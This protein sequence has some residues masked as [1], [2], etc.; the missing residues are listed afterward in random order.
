MCVDPDVPVF[1]TLRSRPH[2]LIRVLIPALMYTVA[3]TMAVVWLCAGCGASS[4]C[5][6]VVTVMALCIGGDF[7][8]RASPYL[9]AEQG[10]FTYR[11]VTA[12]NTRLAPATLRGQACV[13]VILADLF[14]L[15]LLMAC[16]AFSRVPVFSYISMAMLPSSSWPFPVAVLYMVAV[17]TVGLVLVFSFYCVILTIDRADPYR[18]ISGEGSHALLRCH[19]AVSALL[20]VPMMAIT[21]SALPCHDGRMRFFTD[22]AC[23]SGRHRVLGGL[24]LLF[25]GT[26]SATLQTV[27]EVQHRLQEPSSVPL[28]LVCRNDAL[29]QEVLLALRWVVVV[30]CVFASDHVVVFVV[31]ACVAVVG[32]AL[33]RH[34]S[35]VAALQDLFFGL[36]IEVVVTSVACGGLAVLGVSGGVGLL[37]W[38]LVWLVTSAVLLYVYHHR[39][40][41]AVFGSGEDLVAVDFVV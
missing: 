27:A 37:W 21:A 38:F 5:T 30:V 13:C 19:V 41:W 16:S 33:A 25:L 6:V 4:A 36:L 28:P 7:L 31:V 32:W 22:A 39:R 17:A 2:F 24:S 20:M 1:G 9:W 34:P 8:R 40:G 18:F 23:L 14:F 26:V 11:R 10:K 3:I 35:S 15:P 12:A 29:F